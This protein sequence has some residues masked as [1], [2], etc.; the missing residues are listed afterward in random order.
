MTS[1]RASGMTRARRPISGP[2]WGSSLPQIISTGTTSCRS[3]GAESAFVARSD[4]AAWTAA[5]GWAARS[6]GE[7]G[8][9]L[10][11]HLEESLWR[12]PRRHTGR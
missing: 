1:R 3:S 4:Q 12:S 6:Q 2:P 7:A 8:A 11:D 10:V 5:H 9:S